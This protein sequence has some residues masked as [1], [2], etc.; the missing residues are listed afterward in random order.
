MN[1]ASRLEGANKY[2]GTSILITESTKQRLFS[3]FK[4]RRIG[5]VVTKG[6]D[7]SA[8]VYQIFGEGDGA[9]PFYVRD[10]EAALVLFERREY[11][12]AYEKIVTAIRSNGDQDRATLELRTQIERHMSITSDVKPSIRLSEK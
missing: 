11:E 12:K 7:R 8:E 2:F 3:T 6:T 1:L 4:L 9:L 5:P 10:Y